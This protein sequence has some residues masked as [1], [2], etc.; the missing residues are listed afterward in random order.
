MMQNF[1]H[2]V[3]NGSVLVGTFVKTASHQIVEV[4]GV[5]GLDFAIV[6]S[7]HAPFDP[8]TL[9]TM[10]LASQAAALPCLVR[11]PE[12]AH[13]PIGQALDMG[14]AGI[15]AP[16]VKNPAAA[17]AVLDGAKY[18]RGKRGLSPS[19]RAGNYGAQGAAAHRN[20][21]DKD[22]TV[23]CQIEDK[24]ALAHLDAIPA[25]DDIDCLF[26]GRA[27]LAQSLG[28]DRQTDPKLVEAVAAIASAG[29]KH[30]RTI[31]IFIADTGEIPDLMALGITLFVCGSDQ[32]LLKMQAKRIHVDT[33]ALIKKR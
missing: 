31:G 28:V 23:W 8:Q 1:R 11:V 32:S 19:T 14:F 29:R 17:E 3:R 2:A 22:S 25:M 30:K 10:A 20:S 16:H 26:I 12:I 13:S 15:L 27:D 4:L 33:A 24:E 7:E 9:D 6:D 5:S 18:G 21:A